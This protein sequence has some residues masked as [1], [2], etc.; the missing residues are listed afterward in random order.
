MTK[1]SACHTPYLR[2]HTSW[3]SFVVHKCKMMISPGVFFLHFFEILIFQV[4]SSGKKQKMAQNDEKFCLLHSICQEAYSIW[5]WFLVH[6]CKMMSSPALAITDSKRQLPLILPSKRKSSA[7]NFC[8]W[9]F[10]YNLLWTFLY[11]VE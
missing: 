10:I 4:V 11:F 3:S 1:N 6:L 9:S 2:N 8:H 7:A 5:L